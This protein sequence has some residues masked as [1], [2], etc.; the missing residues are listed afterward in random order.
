MAYL[1]TDHGFGDIM[2]AIATSDLPIDRYFVE[3]NSEATGVD[4]YA[5]PSGPG[6]ELVG[7]W[8]AGGVADRGRGMAFAA[9]LAPGQTETARQFAREAYTER[10]ADMD[11]AR[12][13]EGL[14]R[15]EL[16]SSR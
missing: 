4:F 3:Q 2:R 8:V 7:K 13:S 5:P 14:T 16:F 6:P 9:P 11:A 10:G 15:E 12:S 1:E